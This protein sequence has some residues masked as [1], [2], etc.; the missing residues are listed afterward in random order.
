MYVQNEIFRSEIVVR[1]N[2]LHGHSRIH[3]HFSS[4][5]LFWV[6]FL[7]FSLELSHSLYSMEYAASD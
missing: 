3:H 1:E 2:W 7:Y 4:S 5:T 6:S